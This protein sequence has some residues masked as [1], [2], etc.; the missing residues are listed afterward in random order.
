MTTETKLTDSGS[1]ERFRACIDA[2]VARFDLGEPVK[3]MR[4]HQNIASDFKLAQTGRKAN[5]AGVAYWQTTVMF[6]GETIGFPACSELL[7]YAAE[8]GFSAPNRGAYDYKTRKAAATATTTEEIRATMR[9]DLL[10][11]Y[12]A[13]IDAGENEQSRLLGWT[14]FSGIKTSW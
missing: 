10:S 2:F 9:K 6:D 1:P 3:V 7:G 8:Y 4:R 13:I 12:T 5:P 11:W 14:E